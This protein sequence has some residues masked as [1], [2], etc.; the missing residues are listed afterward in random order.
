MPG[1]PALERKNYCRLKAGPIYR[2]KL[3]LE[4]PTE[5]HILLKENRTKTVYEI[6]GLKR[7]TSLRLTWTKYITRHTSKLRTWAWQQA[8]TG[9]HLRRTYSH[10][11]LNQ[12]RLSASAAVN[13]KQCWMEWVCS[14]RIE[15]CKTVL[16][17]NTRD[18]Q[19]SPHPSIH[20]FFPL[21]DANE[22]YPALGPKCFFN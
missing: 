14:G 22:I 3:E 9:R 13:T 11:E 10:P 1:F 21:A 2:V 12:L 8:R 18:V 4:C 19:T 20:I 17:T 6:P 15:G 16:L 5:W 7:P